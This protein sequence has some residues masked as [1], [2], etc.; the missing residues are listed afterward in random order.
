MVAIMILLGVLGGSYPA[1][2]L[3][4]IEPINAI[5][6]RVG[7]KAPLRKTLVSVQLAVVIFV[8]IS[9]GMIYEQLQYLR[10]KDLGFDKEQIV[11]VT[12]PDQVTNNLSQYDALKNS[13]LESTSIS[14][15]CTSNFI[16]GED[17]MGRP[18]IAVDGSPGQEQ[19]F[20]YWGSFDCDFLP[21][22]NIPIRSGRNFSPDFPADTSA[23]IVNEALVRAFNLKVPLGDKVRFG[24]KGNPKFF[25]IV[26]VVTDFHQSSLYTPIEPQMYL[27]RPGIKLFIK[28]ANDIPGAI[29]HIE[30]TWGDFYADS[31]FAY[32]F[33]D[34]ELQDDYKGDQ[35]KGKVFFLLSLLTIFTAFLGLFG[36]ASYLATQRVKEIGIR[37]IL[38][39]RV[40]HIVFL[41][42]SDFLLLALLAAI[43]ASALSWYMI[44]RWLENFAFRTHINYAVF[45]LSLVFTL[46][47]TFVTTGI[48]ART[49]ASANP[50]N[51]LRYE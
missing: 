31:P 12:M 30:Q 1:F 8:L 48:H 37:K 39:A 26:G 43:P 51:N 23:I 17:D 20:V 32:R 19:N 5:K 41:I 29:K 6:D 27:L 45:V 38:V 7:R 40:K 10:N 46:L 34:D 47:L 25:V 16:P 24:G 35:V 9:T 42:T 14:G 21:T 15:V 44:N 2:F 18:P 28:V 36:L 50:L 4:S 22:M 3:A 49:A 11:N 13:L 33:I